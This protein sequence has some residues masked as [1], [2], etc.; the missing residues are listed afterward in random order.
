MCRNGKEWKELRT[1]I[2]KQTLPQNVNSYI[3]GMNDVLRRFTCYLRANRNE[4]EYVEDIL[5]LLNILLL[6]CRFYHHHDFG[7]AWNRATVQNYTF[8]ATFGP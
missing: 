5:E 7:L 6:E 2:G 4:Q 1:A 3:P 8:I